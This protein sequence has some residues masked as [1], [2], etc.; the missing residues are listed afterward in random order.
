MSKPSDWFNSLTPEHQ[1]KVRADCH[2]AKQTLKDI[3]E[4]RIDLP[5]DRLVEMTK[6]P[7]ISPIIYNAVQAWQHG[8]I[9]REEMYMV[10]IEYVAQENKQLRELSQRLLLNGR[11]PAYFVP[12]ES[13]GN[14]PLI[15]ADLI[16]ESMRNNPPDPDTSL[17]R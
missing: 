10:I 1:A 3:S 8:R 2:N 6:D 17:L 5:P 4:Q 16:T 13:A 11:F 12:L 9:D 15:P 7:S 14:I